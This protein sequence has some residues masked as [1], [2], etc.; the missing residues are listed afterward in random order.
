MKHIVIKIINFFR[1]LL[2]HKTDKASNSMG[3][4]YASDVYYLVWEGDYVFVS[5]F[6][7]VSVCLRAGVQNQSVNDGSSSFPGL[8]IKVPVSLDL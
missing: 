7:S 3:W 1:Y 8:D 6:L 4:P 2:V 5:V